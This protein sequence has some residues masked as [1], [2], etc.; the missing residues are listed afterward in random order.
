L[1]VV[2]LCFVKYIRLREVSL[3]KVSMLM[4]YSLNVTNIRTLSYNKCKIAT[5][6]KTEL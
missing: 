4:L 6:R 3:L 2:L 5:N 1:C